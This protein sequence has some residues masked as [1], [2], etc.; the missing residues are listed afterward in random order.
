MTYTF[1]LVCDFP[2]QGTEGTGAVLKW[3]GRINDRVNTPFSPCKVASQSTSISL[4]TRPKAFASI[5]QL[6]YPLEER[7][8]QA[9]VGFSAAQDGLGSDIF[10]HCDGLNSLYDIIFSSRNAS[11]S[12]EHVK[13]SSSID[14]SVNIPVN[15][16]ATGDFFK[17][18][19]R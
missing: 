2:S 6:K 19:K 14:D 7:I 16:A 1:P 5:S 15:L 10:G 8:Y 13:G 11:G 17:H 9:S 3:K 4:S 18:L 12:F